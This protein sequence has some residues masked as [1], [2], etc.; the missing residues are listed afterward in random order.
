MKITTKVQTVFVLIG[1]SQCGKTTLSLKIKQEIETQFAARNFRVNVQHLSS[2]NIRREL[3]NANYD[4]NDMIMLESSQP[5]FE[6]LYTKL[7]LVTSFPIN[8][9]FAIIDTTGL[10]EEFRQKVIQISKEQNYNVEAILFDYAN[11]R[12]YFRFVSG[13]SKIVGEQVNRLKQ[14]MGD[15]T[16]KDFSTIHKIKSP[17]DYEQFSFEISNLNSYLS[18]YLPLCPEYTII[19]DVHEQLET[20]M[21][22]IS[23]HDMTK[24]KRYILLGDYIDKG[25]R[26]EQIVNFLYDHPEIVLVNGNHEQYIY[27]CLNGYRKPM[28]ELAQYFSSLET[29]RKNAELKEKFFQ[30][31]QRGKHFLWYAPQRFLDSNVNAHSFIITHSPC[32]NRVL[33][34]LIPSALKAQQYFY[35]DRKQPKLPQVQ[36]LISEAITNAPYHIFGH[37]TFNRIFSYGNKYGIDTGCVDGNLLSAVTFNTYN[38]RPKLLSVKSLSTKQDLSELLNVE[39][40]LPKL[41]MTDLTEEQSKRIN[42]LVEHGINYISGTIA[43]ADKNGDELES[44]EKGLAYF[45]SQKVTKVCLQPKYMGSRLQVYLNLDLEKCYAVTR[46]G[47]ATHLKL[48]TVYQQLLNKFG[49]YMQQEKIKYLILDT[50]LLPWSA[51]GKELINSHFGTIRAGLTAEHND[52]QEGNF[53]QHFQQ[54]L[55]RYEQSDYEKLSCTTKKADLERQFTS[56]LC[57]TYNALKEFKAHYQPLESHKAATKC[58]TEQLELYGKETDLVCKP[59]DLLKIVYEDGDEWTYVTGDSDNEL[60]VTS[61]RFKFVSEDEYLVLDLQESESV[62]KAK[63]YFEK[64][65]CEGK[66]EGIVIKPEEF[67]DKLPQAV[68]VRNSDYLTIIYG[69]DY[70]F[71]TRMKALLKGKNVR[72]KLETSVKEYKLGV[73]ML[74]TPLTDLDTSEYREVLKEFLY[75]MEQ[76]KQLD[77]RL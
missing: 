2:D 23:P 41:T 6:L 45:A 21:N 76:E 33:G 31:Y 55:Q 18:H 71:P 26:T 59:F 64:H 43:P 69:Y 58:Y 63:E 66:M 70:Q 68:K 38:L 9:E 1:P 3:L 39:E 51:L 34:K 20:L 17:I 24:E 50:E 13:S 57:V 40:L 61:N 54:L 14:K 28:E 22:I 62:Q 60:N 74:K 65:T 35:L 67:N 48:L 42:Y 12:D 10:S 19:G 7:R 25:D 77:P 27:D 73:R 47:F 53:D 5:T 52:L 32:S 49:D 11:R 29:F 36:F 8:V 37:L 75:E 56:R 44:L 16:R 15:F 72:R 46:N 4:R 30:L